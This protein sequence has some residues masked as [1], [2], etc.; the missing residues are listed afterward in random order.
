MEKDK[1]LQRRVRLIATQI[2]IHEVK[3]R[4]G[5]RSFGKLHKRF[6][7]NAHE[8]NGKFWCRN[9]RIF[10]KYANGEKA[11]RNNVALINKIEKEFPGTKLIL[12]HPLWFILENPLS[13]LETIHSLMHSLNPGIQAQLF[14]KNSQT[15]L[16]E[17]KAW[18]YK[19][20]FYYI[21]MH[22]DL[23]ALACFLM[24]IRE[25]E[26]LEH[27]ISY[28]QSKWFAL[29]VFLRLSYFKPLNTV[30][31]DL[32]KIIYEVFIG[33]SNPSAG[34]YNV[35]LTDITYPAPPFL[36]NTNSIN[37]K[38]SN[39]LR[40][41]Q[42][43]GLEEL[44][45]QSQLRLFFWVFIFGLEKI[46]KALDPIDSNSENQE[47]NKK[48][49]SAY[50]STRPKNHIPKDLFLNIFEGELSTWRNLYRK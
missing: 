25:T 45:K 44:D 50:K 3:E 18:P 32:Y 11:I 23:D 38:L 19:Q 6:S 13:D 26:I 7:K 31:D 9:S 1:K 49:I 33:R 43:H 24:I 10:Y 20:D 2:Y 30:A 15:N 28:T 21:D 47:L 41:A 14:K 17:R 8:S 42:H 12:N 40:N 37:G 35:F 36:D 27:W 4:S 48:F 16:Y 22:S 5:E 39:I 34:T 29:G 46:D